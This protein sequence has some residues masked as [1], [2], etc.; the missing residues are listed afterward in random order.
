MTQVRWTK[1]CG[2]EIQNL[3]NAPAVIRGAEAEYESGPCL[4]YIPDEYNSC[5]YH[6]LIS[7]GDILGYAE[8]DACDHE[9][10]GPA[11][12]DEDKVYAALRAAE[13]K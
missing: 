3:I 6:L 5:D 1:Q 12:F 7:Y 13:R 11:H 8:Y 9:G 4:A 10:R 2:V